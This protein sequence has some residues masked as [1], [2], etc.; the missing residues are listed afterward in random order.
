MLPE[1]PVSDGR[2]F[3]NPSVWFVDQDGY[4]V[5]FQRHEP[6]YRIAANDQ[7]HQRLVAV[8]LRQSRLATQEEICRAFG[9]SVAL[10]CGFS[11]ADRM[12]LIFLRL[13]GKPPSAFRPG[14][15]SATAPLLSP[16]R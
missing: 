7:M 12:R 8:M 3:L 6:I 10:Q 4:R 5:V 1:E 15:N 13:T 11:S 16:S 2:T 14:L 9:H